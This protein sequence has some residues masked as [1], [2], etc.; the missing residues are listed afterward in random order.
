M[1]SGKTAIVTGSGRGIDKETAIMLAER[2]V[3]VVVCSRTQREIDKTVDEIKSIHPRVLGVRCDVGK[4]DDVE[5]LVKKIVEKFDSRIDI[6]VNNA[7]IVFL[8]RLEYT[9][10]DEWDKTINSNLKSAFLCTRTVLPY[11]KN[12]GT[13]INVSSSAGKVGF[14]NL[15]AYC[16]SKFGM[17]GL[18][19]SLAR[20]LVNVRVMAVCLGDVDTAMQDIDPEYHRINKD[21]MLSAREV[22]AKIVDMI[23][24]PDK[25]ATG[26]SVDI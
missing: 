2:V 10:E 6:L 14:E 1:S 12:D 17:M 9:T 16:A 4:A 3:N 8:K 21:R 19:A 23:F 13:I 24:S 18:T 25:Y 15:S 22:A 20:E 5:M 7:G 26:Q 11:M